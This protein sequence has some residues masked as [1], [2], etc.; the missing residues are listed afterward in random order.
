MVQ[1][2]TAPAFHVAV[3]INLT[4]ASRAKTFSPGS[5]VTDVITLVCAQALADHPGMN[6]W[7]ESEASV[8]SFDTVNIGI[9]G[10]GPKGSSS[11]WSTT[12]RS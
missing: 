1:A 3:D 9:A 6:S 5:T 12:P 10:A 11:P 2:W 7:F 8:R 4:E